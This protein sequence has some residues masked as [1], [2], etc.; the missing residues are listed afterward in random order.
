LLS[1]VIG[2]IVKIL[3]RVVNIPEKANNFMTYTT[4]DKYIESQAEE[5][6]PILKKIRR[7]INSAA[8]EAVEKISYGIPTFWLGRNLIHFAVYK[9]HIGIY[10]GGE[11]IPV[12]AERLKNYKTSKGAIQFPLDKPID[13]TLLAD[14][15]RWRITQL[16]KSRQ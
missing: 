3:F 6:H 10:P 1:S 11:A 2:T 15:T 9:K 7:T 14:I 16:M 5:I 8:P 12:F 4:I 13:Y